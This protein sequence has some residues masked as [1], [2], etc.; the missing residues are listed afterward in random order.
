VWISTTDITGRPLGFSNGIRQASSAGPSALM[1]GA[2]VAVSDWVSTGATGVPGNRRTTGRFDDGG[3]APATTSVLGSPPE[4]AGAGVSTSGPVEGGISSD[5]EGAGA[6]AGVSPPEGGGE[7][8]SGP[9]PAPPICG[10]R[11]LLPVWPGRLAAGAGVCACVAPGSSRVTNC[12]EGSVAG[13]SCAPGAPAAAGAAALRVS[14]IALSPVTSGGVGCIGAASATATSGPGTAGPGSTVGTAP[15]AGCGSADDATAAGASATPF[16][17]APGVSGWAS[18]A[19]CP[20]PGALPAPVTSTAPADWPSG[21]E[22]RL[23]GASTFGVGTSSAEVSKAGGFSIASSGGITPLAASP[24]GRVS[25]LG[26]TG[27]VSGLAWLNSVPA[28]TSTC[29][30]S[31]FGKL[32]C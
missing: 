13:A 4:G 10:R 29:S 5:T 20:V 32:N 9:A 26:A 8:I 27:S 15:G 28:G 21:A 30:A 31:G 19:L 24:P 12:G 14:G 22:P 6:G 16:G 17:A 1:S 23:P 3:S 7:I 11:S 25:A 18:V 2:G